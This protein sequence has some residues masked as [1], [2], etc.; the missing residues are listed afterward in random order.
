MGYLKDSLYRNNPY[1]IYELKEEISS[2]GIKSTADTVC[3]AVAIVDSQLQM[4]VSVLIVCIFNTFSTH[5]FSQFYYA[6]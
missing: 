4:V 1:T 5:R 6:K 3:R 2:V